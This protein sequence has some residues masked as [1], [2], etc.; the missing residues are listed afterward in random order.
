MP[1]TMKG[2]KILA[3]MKKTYGSK[4]AEEVFYA[5]IKSKKIKGVEKKK[6]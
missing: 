1:L 2:K 6:K 4:K 5:M 3:R